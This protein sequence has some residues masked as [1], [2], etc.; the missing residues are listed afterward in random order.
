MDATKIHSKFRSLFLHAWDLADEGVDRVMD[1][2]RAAGLNTLCMASTYH[3]GWFIHPGNPKH[4]AFMTEGS[5]CYF[6]P[7][8]SHYKETSLRP[9]PANLARKKDWFAEAGKRL[10][11][12]DL[13]LVAWTI[14]T[15]NTR[16]G[17]KHPHLTQQNVYGDR[18]PH[19]LCP[20]NRD[21]RHYLLALCRDLATNYP[22]WGIQAEAFG[23]MGFVHGHHHER[24]L[25]GLTPLE[26]DLMGLCLCRACAAAATRAGVD[27]ASV[28][29]IIKTTLDGAFRESPQRPGNHPNSMQRLERRSP[30]LKKFNLWRKAFANDLVKEIKEHA[31]RGTDCRLLLQTPFDPVLEGVADGFACIAYGTPPLQTRSICRQSVAAL[32]RN[33]PGILQCLVQLGMGVP[34]SERQLRGIVNAIATSGC[35]GVNF[36]N[37]SESPPKMLNWLKAAMKEF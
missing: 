30:A 4:R 21:V 20:A 32:P 6:H 36:Y 15:H 34:E 29:Q 3:S 22:L 37:R 2:I 11:K 18:L 9:I 27:V 35:N 10:K 5:V 7:T 24:D 1:S 12:H 23:W 28:R 26:Q 14:G 17:L 8:E 31:L 13:R 16:L 33:W 25:V 19:A